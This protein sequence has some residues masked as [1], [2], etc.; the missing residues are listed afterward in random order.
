MRLGILTLAVGT[1][2]RQPLTFRSRSVVLGARVNAAV[3]AGF[4]SLREH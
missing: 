1:D 4:R 2:L 3:V